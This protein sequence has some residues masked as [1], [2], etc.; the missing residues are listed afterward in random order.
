M[1]KEP[2]YIESEKN[3]PNNKGAESIEQD[4]HNKPKESNK[5]LNPRGN[6]KPEDEIINNFIWPNNEKD[7]IEKEKV[8]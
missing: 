3:E 5:K 1:K 2:H 4:P 7:K 6:N 8:N